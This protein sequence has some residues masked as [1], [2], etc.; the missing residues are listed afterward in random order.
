MRKQQKNV[1]NNKSYSKIIILIILISLAKCGEDYYRLLG[2]KRNASKQEI[3]RAFKKLSL[4]Y[5]PDKNKNNPEKA[6]EMF[7]KIAN[8]YEVLNDDKMRKIYDQYGEEGVKQSQA[9][10]GQGGGF[11]GFHFNF[12]GGGGNFEDIFSQFFGGGRGGF[13][14][15]TG[16]R[17]GEDEGPEKDFFDN[18][19]VVT[20]KMNNLSKI[21]SRRKI[22]YVYFFRSKDEGFKEYMETFKDIASKTYGIFEFGAVN[23][24]DDEEICDEYSVHSTPKLFYFPDSGKD[25]EEYTG[26]LEF[27]SILKFGSRQMQNFVRIINKDNYNDFLSSNSDRFH[28]LLFTSKKSTPPL[29]KALSKD[30]LNKLSFGEIRNSE[31]ELINSFGI[32]EFPTLM[33]LKDEEKDEVDI[34]KDELKFDPIKKFLLKY[35]YKKKEENKNIK[36]R[37][38]NSNTYERLGMCGY[39]DNKNICLVFLINT[40]KPIDSEYKTLESLGD[41]YMNDHIKVFY[42]NI[43]KYKNI[44]KSFNNDVNFENTKAI[45]IKGKR[46]KYLAI[47][48]EAFSSN[49]FYSILDNIINGSGDF[50]KLQKGLI[51]GE[52]KDNKKQTESADL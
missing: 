50:K 26:K 11:G 18:T 20:L 7:V 41:K 14:F 45:I 21:L 25:E 3:R 28:V 13:H 36:V 33:V 34:F 15:S 10:N 23:C 29:F 22:W 17:G 19:D 46:K 42:L 16:G 51:L 1:H 24:R 40:P 47:S 52:D 44:F 9:T 8:A 39:N 32:K 6:K 12:G 30:Y 48:K 2:V 43:N 5:H 27:Q 4:K 49:E 38:L 35:A 31:T 37:E